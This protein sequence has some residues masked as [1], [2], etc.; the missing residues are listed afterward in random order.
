MKWRQIRKEVKNEVL[1]VTIKEKN[2]VKI[3]RE[4]ENNNLQRQKC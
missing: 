4:S 1:E 2:E 3:D